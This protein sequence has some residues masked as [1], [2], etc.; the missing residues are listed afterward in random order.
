M[1]SQSAS[2]LRVLLVYPRFAGNLQINFEYMVPFYPGRRAV[3]PPLGLLTFAGALPAEWELRLVD[4]NV[5]PLEQSDLDWA[6]VVAISG[7]HP[8]R[9]RIREILRQAR[10]CEKLSV[11]GGPSVSIVPEAYPE[12]D[13]LHVGELGDATQQLIAH[14]RSRPARPQ[15][16]LVFRTEVKTPMDE[17]PLPALE[18]VDVN[19]YLVMPVQFSVGCP[20]HCEFC[21]I[22]V[23]FGSDTRSKSS[24][25]VVRELQ[26]IYDL[27]FVG[28]ISFVD[29]N[30]IGD[31]NTLGE[32]L[33]ALVAWQR[34]HGYPYSFS[35]EASLNLARDP[36]SLQGLHDA[37]FTHLFIGLESL[38]TD[39][40]RAISKPQNT[41]QPILDALRTIQSY[42]LELL[43]GMIVGFDNDTPRVGEQMVR[44]V[45]QAQVPI[46]YF[47][48]LT[49]LPRTPLWMR[50]EAEGRLMHFDDD[51][52]P[53]RL[54]SGTATNVRYK[55]PNQLVEK[56]L[57]ETI[58]QVYHP[59]AVYRRYTWN[60]VAVYGKQL[61]GTPPLRTWRQR[62]RLLLFVV[63]MVWRVLWIIGVRSSQR[64][65]F[66]PFVAHMLALR[67]RG[68]I[69]N[70]FEVL[71]KAPP[72]AYHLITWAERLLA[73]ADRRE[74]VVVA[75]AADEHMAATG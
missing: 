15:G 32:L 72:H 58:R 5:R 10:R 42:G 3:M 19:Q 27:G 6:E 51:P 75:A 55:L 36:A 44:F 8:Q 65:Y 1:T 68:Q 29:D 49:A 20:F 41:L 69:H 24:P 16:Q 61:G 73:E 28:V 45:E 22:P 18:L 54:L 48:L 46:I 56:I 21:D 37:R 64:R 23:I 62:Q 50:L 25:R 11:L 38:E 4:E 67:W 39:T 34:A 31:R 53:D 59:A 60:A 30:L 14:L 17:L 33:P 9:A 47:N 12:A 63:G 40:L 66:W 43:L 52:G 26:A 74:A 57:I 7:M 13:L 2:P 35:G 71:L 70:F